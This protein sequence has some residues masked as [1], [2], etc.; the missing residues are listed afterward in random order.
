MLIGVDICGSIMKYS[1]VDGILGGK[2][3]TAKS[4]Q[5]CAESH[6]KKRK[7]EKETEEGSAK[8]EINRNNNKEKNE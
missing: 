2:S 3:G 1:I 6:L 7:K 4:T 5:Y 8:S